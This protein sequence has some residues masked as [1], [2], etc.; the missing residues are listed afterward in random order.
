MYCYKITF[1]RPAELVLDLLDACELTLLADPGLAGWRMRPDPVMGTL[2]DDPG[3]LVTLR[4]VLDA[5]TEG[6]VI[7][8]I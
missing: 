8:A 1:H 2:E 5:L 7:D 4:G 6:N 3:G